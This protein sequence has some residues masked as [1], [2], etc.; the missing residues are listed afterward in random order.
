MATRAT[1]DK[2]PGIALRRVLL[3]E[4]HPEL[5]LHVDPEHREQAR[6]GLSVPCLALRTGDWDPAVIGATGRQ[7]FGAIVSSG[8]LCRTLHTGGHPALE[9][10]GPGDVIGGSSLESSVLAA[11]EA[12]IVSAPAR[13]VMLDDEFLLAARRWPR[14][15]TGIFDLMRQQH[16]RLALQMVIAAQPRVED[17]LTALFGLLS[18]R[19]GRVTGAGVVVEVAL[20]HE[21]IGRLIGAQRPTVSLALKALSGRDVLQR[22]PGGWWL[23]PGRPAAT[24]PAPAPPVGPAARYAAPSALRTGTPSGT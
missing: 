19:Y 9:L 24:A 7:A 13:L 15:V 23:L 10:F 18:E 14:L 5:A 22:R 6:A 8:L 12:W 3:L 17:R 20:T 16:D 1:P 4:E 21:A 11:R 2:T